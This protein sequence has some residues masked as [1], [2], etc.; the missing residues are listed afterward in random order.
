[1]LLLRSR[2]VVN[3][4]DVFL[5]NSSLN[6]Y[7]V[8]R[9]H[10]SKLDRSGNLPVLLHRVRPLHLSDAI[11][12]AQ[13]VSILADTAVKLRATVKEVAVVSNN[14]VCAA[15]WV[16]VPVAVVHELGVIGEAKAATSKL[17]AIVPIVYVRVIS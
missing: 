15:V 14:A 12:A 17:V 4:L 13:I 11:L 5:L 9:S 7:F 2:V 1:M 10:V 8:P 3:I 6:S 16:V